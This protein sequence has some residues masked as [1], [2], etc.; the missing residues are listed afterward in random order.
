MTTFRSMSNFIRAGWIIDFRIHD[1]KDIVLFVTRP[2]GAILRGASPKVAID[3]KTTHRLICKN[4][5]NDEVFVNSVIRSAVNELL[6]D[7]P[8]SECDSG[9]PA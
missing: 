3:S 4:V 6:S 7:L 9:D 8:L 5:F 2:E 1:D